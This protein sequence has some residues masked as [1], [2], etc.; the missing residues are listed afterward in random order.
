MLHLWIV[1]SLG[2]VHF[3]GSTDLVEYPSP[4]EIPKSSVAV[5]SED[6]RYQGP[7]D[8]PDRIPILLEDLRI[9]RSR[10]CGVENRQT[11]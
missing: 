3:V 5:I 2:P 4:C 1:R 8:S 6:L 11:T 7:C 9:L 10:I